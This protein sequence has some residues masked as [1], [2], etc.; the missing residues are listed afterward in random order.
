M[1]GG[2]AAELSPKSC[3][4]PLCFA[5]LGRHAH[6]TPLHFQ[7]I[8][9]SFPKLLFF[10]LVGLD[11]CVLRVLMLPSPLNCKLSLLTTFALTYLVNRCALQSAGHIPSSMICV[12][13]QSLPWSSI[14]SP[15]GTVLACVPC[16]HS[17]YDS[18]GRAALFIL[19]LLEPN[20]LI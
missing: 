12:L 13:V 15:I 19:T 9:G 8:F 5:R 2:C 1:C 18:N 4:P 6:S 7:L 10:G 16:L 14:S 3:S 11:L 20:T 17:G